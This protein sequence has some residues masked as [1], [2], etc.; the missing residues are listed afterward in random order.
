MLDA[1]DLSDKKHTQAGALSGGMK[2]KLQVRHCNK[3]GCQGDLPMV[4]SSAQE[5]VQPAHLAHM[6]G[7]CSASCTT[8]SDRSCDTTSVTAAAAPHS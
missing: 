6:K 2:R 1:V 5:Y 7:P 3:P 8:G 4:T